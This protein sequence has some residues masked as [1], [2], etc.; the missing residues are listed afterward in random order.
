MGE[1]DNSDCAGGFKLGPPS[2]SKHTWDTYLKQLSLQRDRTEL[3][4]HH[5][6]ILLFLKSNT[7]FIIMGDKSAR[8]PNNPEE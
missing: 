8:Q 3:I 7:N 2:Q 1:G 4:C 5:V 6:T